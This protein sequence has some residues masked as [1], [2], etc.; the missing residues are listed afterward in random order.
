MGI[1]GGGDKGGELVLDGLDVAG[2]LAV[3]DGAGHWVREDV[4]LAGFDPVEAGAR[5]RLGR[6]L[7]DVDA[8]GHVGVGRP[9]QP[10]VHLHARP[11]SRARS[12]WVM[13]KAVAFDTT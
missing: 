8:A 4:L 11:A 5:H 12:D 1:S 6:G 7:G 2:P 9:G 10:G 13:L 3:G